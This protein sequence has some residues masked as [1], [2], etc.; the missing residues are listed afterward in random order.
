[1]SPDD[2]P[3]TEG[4]QRLTDDAPLTKCWPLLQHQFKIVKVNMEDLIKLCNERDALRKENNRLTF[5][6]KT[7]IESLNRR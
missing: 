2:A 4:K 5:R 6:M 7:M 1:M 3:L